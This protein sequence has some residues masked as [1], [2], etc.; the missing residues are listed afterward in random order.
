MNEEILTNKKNSPERKK[1]FKRRWAI[2]ALNAEIGGS[3]YLRG[4]KVYTPGYGTEN[5]ESPQGE[6]C[7]YG[8]RL[9][10]KLSASFSSEQATFSSLDFS[11]ATVDGDVEIKECE[12]THCLLLRGCEVNGNI[13]L[14]GTKFSG[15]N[16]DGYSVIGRDLRVAEMLQFGRE[17]SISCS[18]SKD[19]Q[20]REATSNSD[21]APLSDQAETTGKS[22]SNNSNP[23]TVSGSI[24]LTGAHIG[25]NLLLDN[26]DILGKTGKGKRSIRASSIQVGGALMMR[27]TTVAGAV[28]LRVA[29]IQRIV[30]LHGVK[31]NHAGDGFPSLTMRGAYVGLD[32][33]LGDDD[34]KDLCKDNCFFAKWIRLN[35][36]QVNGSLRLY[37]GCIEE[38]FEAVGI[39]VGGDFK[40]ENTKFTENVDLS[41][42]RVAG[43]F[44]C[45][46]SKCKRKCKR[47]K[48]KVTFQK[49]IKM[50]NS[51]IGQDVRFT[52][53]I[54][55]KQ[56]KPQGKVELIGAKI[57]GALAVTGEC[58][59]PFE[60][61]NMSVGQDV[62]LRGEDADFVAHQTVRLDGSEIKGNLDC[63]GGKF[64]AK[65]SQDSF[66]RGM[67]ELFKSPTDYCLYAA[68]ISVGQSV[69]LGVFKSSSETGAFTAEG[70]VCFSDA[71]IGRNFDCRGG[72]FKD[73]SE[74]CLYAPRVKVGGDMSFC[75]AREDNQK[76]FTAH[77]TVRIPGAQVEGDIDFGGADFKENKCPYSVYATGIDVKGSVYF[78]CA[79]ENRGIQFTA[80]GCVRL[81]GSKI[82][83]NLD[84]R[85]GQF[86]STDT[87]VKNSTSLQNTGNMTPYTS[88]AVY[89]LYAPN[90]EVGGNIYCG[91]LKTDSQHYYFTSC[92][93]VSFAAAKVSGNI[94]CAG[95]RFQYKGS[96]CLYA[97][98]IEVGRGVR[99]GYD[100]DVCESS[101]TFEAFGT[102]RL[103]GAQIAGNLDCGGGIF[104]A[105]SPS[106]DLPYSCSIYATGAKIGGNLY[107]NKY[108]EAEKRFTSKAV[109]NLGGVTVQ[110]KVDCNEGHFM[111]E[112]QAEDRSLTRHNG[113]L[114][115]LG[116]AQINWHL[117]LTGCEI[118][119]DIN[120]RGASI[121]GNIEAYGTKVGESNKEGRNIIARDIKVARSVYLGRKS[122]KENQKAEGSAADSEGKD[123]KDKDLFVASKV[124]LSKAEIGHSLE[125]WG[126]LDEFDLS[127]ATVGGD[128]VFGVLGKRCPD[129]NQP[130]HYNSKFFRRIQSIYFLLGVKLFQEILRKDKEEYLNANRF[131]FLDWKDWIIIKHLISG[132]RNSINERLNSKS[133]DQEKQKC[134]V[135]I[136]L[137]N[138]SVDIWD[139][140]YVFPEVPSSDEEPFLWRMTRKQIKRASEYN[141]SDFSYSGLGEHLLKCLRE[142]PREFGLWLNFANVCEFDP[143]PYEHLAEILKKHGEEAGYAAIVVAKRR[144]HRQYVAPARSLRWIIGL[145]LLLISIML[146]IF[147]MGYFDGWYGLSGNKNEKP[148]LSVGGL[149]T[150]FSAY[151]DVTIFILSVLVSFGIVSMLNYSLSR[152]L[153]KPVGFIYDMLT[154]HIPVHLV[155]RPWRAP[156]YATLIWVI[157]SLFYHAVDAKSYMA[158]AEGHLQYYL[159]KDFKSQ[160]DYDS[161]HAHKAETPKVDYAQVVPQGYPAYNPLL[162]TLDRL[163]PLVEFAQGDV[164]MPDTSKDMGRY[165]WYLDW[166]LRIVGF[167]LVTVLLGAITGLVKAEKL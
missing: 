63:R 37:R 25:R 32:L 34:Y 146:W 4:V 101:T 129:D 72:I 111:N 43:S 62:F 130:K 23:I 166:L 68:G 158:P 135:C 20:G 140:Y 117:V 94:D 14:E 121:G 27:Y 150:Q 78:N 128:F 132:T 84:C 56:T 161:S 131:F 90:I 139:D 108:P 144:E 123:Q 124:D 18:D 143:Q 70:A 99:L 105:G 8:A 126:E 36:I 88:P 53:V 30:S 120:L 118:K 24:D 114:V 156:A 74:R 67:H 142:Y 106:S 107:L 153:F 49:G 50:Y 138:A 42:A 22:S 11:E 58:Y 73:S 40:I 119:G 125:I 15:K 38:V 41:G 59:L 163:V 33:L 79:L 148:L 39:Q 141:L 80:K 76:R 7:F 97:P 19:V 75:V 61:H 151:S 3:V 21:N 2:F 145:Y 48:S 122:T 13:T 57:G 154:L 51:S 136:N 54:F 83:R 159:S 86:N 77:G 5:Q 28:D 12:V 96:R 116:G 110:G 133:K 66:M 26:L 115:S 6:I 71:K 31:L 16:K 98:Q 10:S 69:Y 55:G 82:G 164:W 92:G 29:Q 160:M 60:A 104:G 109:V 89:A 81:D 9:K 100:P 47:A 35:G 102:V 52:D 112:P 103:E 127:S 165:L 95:G 162:Y 93:P 1:L 155:A 157:A 64:T 85:G 167:Y 17:P 44:E 65:P 134:K 46:S 137:R 45:K 152:L 149:I 113:Y 147:G 91:A 87:G